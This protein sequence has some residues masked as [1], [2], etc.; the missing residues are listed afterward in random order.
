MSV[1]AEGIENERQLV[2]LIGL[3]CETGQ[4]FYFSEPLEAGVAEK[5]LEDSSRGDLIMP[6]ASSRTSPGP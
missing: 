4:G 5:L 6:N 2:N 3:G 1:V